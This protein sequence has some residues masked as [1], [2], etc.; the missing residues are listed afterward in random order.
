M[1]KLDLIE[2]ADYSRPNQIVDEII[3]QNPNISAP[4]PIEEIADAAGICKIEY[5]PLGALEGAL[6]ANEFKSKGVIIVNNK[7]DLHHRQKYTIGHELGHFMIPSHNHEMGC[8]IEYMKN[9]NGLAKIEA[10]ANEFSSKILMPHTIFRKTKYFDAFPSISN[11]QEQAA[12]FDVSLEACINRYVALHHDAVL[13]IF[14]KDKKFRYYRKS[15]YIPFYFSQKHQKGLPTVFG[16]LSKKVDTKI[17]N[18]YYEEYVDA[19]VWFDKHN[20]YV[21]PEEVLEEVYVQRNGY[22]VTLLKFEEEIEEI[23]H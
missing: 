6:V 18:Q 4:V 1:I 3:S 23:E 13:A 20:D 21:L 12:L 11:T 5:E 8:S 19:S 15:D 10:Q 17:E 14:Y 7:D 9:N 2:F 16:S 22:S